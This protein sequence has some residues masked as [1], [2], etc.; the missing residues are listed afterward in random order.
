M[1][2]YVYSNCQNVAFY[3]DVESTFKFVLDDFDICEKSK[4]DYILTQPTF[5]TKFTTMDI[6][7]KFDP[8]KVIIYANY[9][10]E[11]YYLPLTYVYFENKTLHQPLDY[12]FNEIIHG[13]QNKF[14]VDEIYDSILDFDVSDEMIQQITENNVKHAFDN[15]IFFKNKCPNIVYNC[16]FLKQHYRTQLLGYSMNHPT[17]SYMLW[18][19]NEIKQFMDFNIKNETIDM[20]KHVIIPIYPKIKKHFQFEN[21]NEFVFSNK[22]FDL[23]GMIEYYLNE[24]EKLSSEERYVLM[25]Y[26]PKNR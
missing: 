9:Y 23:R 4:F 8:Q 11:S 12:H 26:R 22:K 2:V 16:D 1:K 18:L 10:L 21:E 20:F 14:T 6:L 13:Y 19:T 5:Y 25:N 24:Y 3:M 15:L 7:R 17:L